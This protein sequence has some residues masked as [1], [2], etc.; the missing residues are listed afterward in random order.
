MSTSSCS[1]VF[2]LGKYRVEFQTVDA[3]ET[4]SGCCSTKSS[5]TVS[6][7]P[8]KQLLIGL[9]CE[10]GEFPVLLLLHGF[11]L[12]N[13]FYSQLIQHIAS[14]GFIVISPQASTTLSLSQ[15]LMIW[16][17]HNS[18]QV[19][20]FSQTWLALSILAYFCLANYI[21]AYRSSLHHYLLFA[22]NW[23]CRYRFII[24]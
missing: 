5:S 7:R 14:H 19:C 20:C 10:A 9:P 2:E 6:L 1:N 13:S 3:A 11:L 8:P 23:H 24:P 16:T 4:S 22:V 15:N 21:F 18:V 12:S 17:L